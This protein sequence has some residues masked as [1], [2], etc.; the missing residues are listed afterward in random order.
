MI[1]EL[2]AFAR[3]WRLCGITAVKP[4]HILNLIRDHAPIAAAA[5]A[6]RAPRI[7]MTAKIE[8]WLASVLLGTIL[9]SAAWA[10]VPHIKLPTLPADVIHSARQFSDPKWPEKKRSKKPARIK[11]EAQV[12]DRKCDQDE[13]RETACD[14]SAPPEY[15]PDLQ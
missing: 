15:Q 12:P 8:S 7:R 2:T 9:C 1:S 10:A 13:K 3:A 4:T 11:I 14:M 6:L 5:I